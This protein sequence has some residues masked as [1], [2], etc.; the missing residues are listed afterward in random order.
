M[1]SNSLPRLHYTDAVGIAV[2]AANADATTVATMH[3]N[4]KQERKRFLEEEEDDDNQEEKKEE[5]KEQEKTLDKAKDQLIKK[6][7]SLASAAVTSSISSVAPEAEAIAIRFRDLDFSENDD[8]YG[9]EEDS[10]YDPD[11]DGD[12]EDDG[13][14][15]EGSWSSGEDSEYWEFHSDSDSGSGD[16]RDEEK[17]AKNL[18]LSAPLG[19]NFPT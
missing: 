14:D 11:A 1:E 3:K 5:E 9:D 18:P 17:Q 7:G 12:Y 10:D 4:L 16:S 15:Y 8:E 6:E 2:L 19:P 13:E